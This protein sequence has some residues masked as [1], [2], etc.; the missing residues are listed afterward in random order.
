MRYVFPIVLLAASVL[1]CVCAAPSMVSTLYPAASTSA[2]I[3]LP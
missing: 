1:L 2:G 3:L